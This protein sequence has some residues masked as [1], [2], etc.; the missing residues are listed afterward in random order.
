MRVENLRDGWLWRKMQ[1]AAEKLG[2]KLA[3]ELETKQKAVW[4]E[5]QGSW[6]S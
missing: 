2:Q 6:F 3:E 5:Q 1:V 4:G